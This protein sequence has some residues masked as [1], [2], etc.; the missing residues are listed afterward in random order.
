MSGENEQARETI[1]H[2]KEHVINAIAETMDLY[3][4]TPSAG[5]LYGTMYFEGSMT[6]DEMKEEL[7][8]SKPSMSTAV[9]KLQDSNM[10]YKTW[11]KGSRR[12]KFVAQKDFFKSFIRFFCQKW[13]RE[14]QMNLASIKAAEIE[15]KQ[16]IDNPD[17]DKAIRQEAQKHFDQINGSKRYYRW[18]GELIESV[19]SGEIFKHI[20]KED[21]E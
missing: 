9:K 13:E 15:L 21:E 8:M 16:V 3:G 18:L 4:V 1:E 20:A 7:G 17:V 14:V 11:E 19:E 2:A 6:L 5:R 12:D 10:V